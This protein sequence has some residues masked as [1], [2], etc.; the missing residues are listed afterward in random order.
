MSAFNSVVTE[1]LIT[2]MRELIR[3]IFDTFEKNWS[4]F[5]RNRKLGTVVQF[6]ALTI[7]RDDAFKK[8][9]CM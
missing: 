1:N 5:P 8:M 7:F 4:L 6:G 3:M 2:S 9:P